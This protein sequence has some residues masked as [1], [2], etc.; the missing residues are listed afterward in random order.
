MKVFGHHIHPPIVLLAAVEFG[1]AGLA[2][3][4]SAFL[5]V[6]M[7][8][9]EEAALPTGTLVFAAI[10]F[11]V[12]VLVG[13]TSVGLY[14][15]KQR[16]RIEGVLARILV[17]LLLAAVLLA[18]IDFF[19]PVGLSGPLWGWSF[20]FSLAL[21]ATTR[22]LCWRWVDNSVFRRNVLVYGAGTRAASLLKLR[23][24]SDRRGF[25]IRAFVPAEGDDGVIDDDRVTKLEGSLAAYARAQNVDEIVVAVDD[26]RRGFPI[27]DLLECK[28]AGIA[29]V[30]LLSFLER[31]TGKVK[32]DLV[33]PSWLIFAEGFEASARSQLG[34]RV[35]DL[36][37]ATA[38][39][40][41]AA[42]VMCLCALAILLEDGP[43]VFY[44]QR[45]V[46]YRGR[47]FTLYKFRSM[48]KDAEADGAPRWAGT[49]DSRITRVGA[50]IRKLRLD[51]LPQLLNVF[52][53]DMALVGPRPERPE[54][55]ERLSQTIP[56]Y[57][58][59]HAV[60]PGITGWAQLCYPYGSSVQDAMEKLQYDL[61]YIKHKSV[62]F[63]LIVLL[64][65]A[66][67]VLWGKGAR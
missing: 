21:L 57:H 3:A 56:Y 40:V 45:R 2:F 10:A 51:E 17:G 27:R 47:T 49:G 7:N 16:L 4:A 61:Y 24:R 43:P 65:T 44:R 50:V 33:H 36:V 9:P 66:E 60:K 18:L 32:V 38:L 41:L 42:P 25:N 14:Q 31:E 35:L 1:A 22:T 55:V 11:S 37:A 34:S 67:V 30:D 26:R 19:F 8:A 53:G 13:V 23:R 20:V 46:G 6:M 29:V 15:A 52:R 58:E 54:F 48:I 12:A 39:L 28:F 59:R 63:D 62:I 5:I 64:Q